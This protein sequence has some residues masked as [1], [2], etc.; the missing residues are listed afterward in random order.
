MELFTYVRKD[1]PAAAVKQ[2]GGE[3]QAGGGRSEIDL[4]VFQLAWENYAVETS[5]V[6]EVHPLK[7]LTPIPCTP[8]FG[9][10]SSATLPA[11]TRRR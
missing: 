3:E 5:F 11:T 1:D 4:L 10:P 2:A 9:R 7:E 8:P 6:R